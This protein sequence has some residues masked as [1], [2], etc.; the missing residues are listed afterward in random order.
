MSRIATLIFLLLSTLA[1]WANI[2]SGLGR[3]HFQNQA[4][5]NP[6]GTFTPQYVGVTG[7]LDWL[8]RPGG[9]KLDFDWFDNLGDRRLKEIKHLDPAA[10]VIS[11]FNYLYDAAGEI[12]RWTQWH[13]GLGGGVAPRRWELGYDLADQLLRSE[14][15]DDTS[16]ALVKLYGYAYDAAG[17]RTSEQADSAVVGSAVNGFNQI[18]GRTAG[19]KA[20]VVGAVSEPSTVKVNGAAVPVTNNE[21][22]AELNV[23][24]GVNTFPVEATETTFPPGTNAQKT[25]KTL[26]I[27]VPGSTAQTLSYDLNGSLTADGTGRTYQWDGANRLVTIVYPGNTKTRFSY[28]ALGRR[29]KIVEENAAGTVTGEKRFVWEGMTIAE[30]NPRPNASTPADKHFGPLS[31]YLA[32][33]FTIHRED[34]DGSVYVRRAL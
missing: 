17:N 21:W 31:L 29:V 12:T 1:D 4:W 3:P 32:A 14:V 20:Q 13:S 2:E 10:A 26:T 27:T 24:A 9:G 34:E 23:V 16:G 30:A 8:V 33:G 15:R 19:G 28:D 7:R 6:I 18:T 5:T 25:T 11:K 22:R